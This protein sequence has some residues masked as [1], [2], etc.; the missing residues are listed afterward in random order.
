M[1]LKV[2]KAVQLADG[3]H[4]GKIIAVRYRDKPFEYTDLEIA[5]EG[6]ILKAGYPTKIMQE[7]KLGLL[8]KRF[9]VLVAEGMTVD[10]DVLTG[11][12]CEFMTMQKPGKK[13]GVFANIIPDSV[14]PIGIQ[15]ANTQQ[16]TPKEQGTPQTAGTQ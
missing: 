3:R 1:K 14:K 15:N 8:L 13:G 2:E 9:G 7:S 5:S 16:N 11:R 4:E 12:D 6:A 10:P